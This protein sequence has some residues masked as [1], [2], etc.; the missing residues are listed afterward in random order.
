MMKGNKIRVLLVDDDP[1]IAW[2]V[3]RCLT[4][5]NC[6]VVTCGD[7][8]E[9]INL[10]REKTF[11]VLVTDIQMP[12]LNGL[13]LIEWVARHRQK[14]RIVA[15]TAFG[16]PSVQQVVL[17][18]GA[19]LY[20][21]KPFDP[22]ILKDLI[23]S[24]QDSSSFYG[25]IDKVDLFDY[26]QLIFHTMRKVIL[27]VKSADGHVGLLYIKNGTACHAECGALRGEE[28]FYKCMSFEGGSFSTLP[29]KEPEA[30]TI[31]TKGEFLLMD[32]AR[33]KDE[34]SG[35]IQPRHLVSNQD[36]ETGFDFLLDVTE[37]GKLEDDWSNE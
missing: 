15:I 33:E 4:R 13:A 6:A 3:G 24:D 31:K 10:L 27:K 26:V 18:K 22:N 9:A 21:E 29:W 5:A 7:G 14:I 8:A 1:E 30:E 20:L 28:A 17:R 36:G 16:C 37:E 11:D 25:N 2:A 19:I 12:K 32:A 23:L 35:A 34:T